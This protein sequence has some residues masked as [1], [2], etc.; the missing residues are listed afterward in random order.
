M[1]AQQPIRVTSLPGNG[2]MTLS[3]NMH[4]S[5]VVDTLQKAATITP[6]RSLIES[7]PQ[8]GSWLLLS[9]SQ[10]TARN[11]HEGKPFWPHEKADLFSVEPSTIA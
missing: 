11:C 4:Y 1:A 9:H 5:T 7:V 8:H 2:T 6:L 3:L 10:E